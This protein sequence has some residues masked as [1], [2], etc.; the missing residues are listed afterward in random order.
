MAV[1][2]REWHAHNRMPERAT[3][4]E[5][6]AWHLAHSAHCACRQMPESIRLELDR[7]GIPIPA[8]PLKA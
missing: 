4:D 6:V 3:L 1:I 7:R 8:T 5:R 2:N